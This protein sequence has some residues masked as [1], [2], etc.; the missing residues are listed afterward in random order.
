MDLQRMKIDATFRDRR[1][2]MNRSQESMEKMVALLYRAPRGG[3][4]EGLPVRAAAFGVEGTRRL[5]TRRIQPATLL[6]FRLPRPSLPRSPGILQPR[7][8]QAGRDGDGSATPVCSYSSCR[9]GS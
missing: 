3:E 1:D 8:G 7:P 5:P 6:I 4:S 9:S 2:R